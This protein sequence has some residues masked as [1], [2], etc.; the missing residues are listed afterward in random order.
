MS[1]HTVRNDPSARNDRGIHYG[2]CLYPPEDSYKVVDGAYVSGVAA[3]LK[4]KA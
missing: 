1:G 4:N 2:G 3:A